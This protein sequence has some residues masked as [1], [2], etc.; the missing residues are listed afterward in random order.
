M[1]FNEADWSKLPRSARRGILGQN[2]QH[3]FASVTNQLKAALPEGAKRVQIVEL[4]RRVTA[5]GRLTAGVAH[6]VKNPL[7]AMTI[8]LELMKQNVQMPPGTFY[9]L[10][11]EPPWPPRNGD[12]ARVS[13]AK[14]V[15]D[16]ADL[17]GAF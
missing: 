11:R 8:H 17:S 3:I 1:W 6:E 16:G 10:L 4:S 2:L 13:G 9:F 7:N 15:V 5:L 12:P 14:V